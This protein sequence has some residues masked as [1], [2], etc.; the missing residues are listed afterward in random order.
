MPQVTPKWCE[1]HRSSFLGECPFCK[2]GLEP[3]RFLEARADFAGLPLAGTRDIL[4]H[5][6]V[7]AIE[8]VLGVLGQQLLT[9]ERLE[10]AALEPY[11]QAKALLYKE[12]RRIHLEPKAMQQAVRIHMGLPGSEK[13]TADP[14]IMALV[15]VLKKGVG[16]A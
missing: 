7:V 12:M 5:Y 15:G 3:V 16:H 9:L 2:A 4:P 14:R 11:A 6:P 8:D 1:D 13:L 10:Q